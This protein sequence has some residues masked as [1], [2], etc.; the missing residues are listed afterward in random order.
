MYSVVSAVASIKFKVS[1]VH[2]SDADLRTATYAGAAKLS[3]MEGLFDLWITARHYGM[4]KDTEV[5]IQIG[6]L[7]TSG[8]CVF[9]DP[10]SDVSIVASEDLGILSSVGRIRFTSD[11]AQGRLVGVL[12]FPVNSDNNLG[13][14]T[15]TTGYVACTTAG[16]RSGLPAEAVNW[17]SQRFFMIDKSI[18][19]GVSGGPVI[20]TDG[21][22]L[23]ML[24]A[25]CINYSQVSWVLKSSYMSDALDA[26]V[27]SWVV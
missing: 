20:D 5:I 6:K 11:V 25:S 17:R 13:T 9:D 10:T 4:L 23:G 2:S 12:G 26:V 3:G 22:V 8:K 27:E 24:C 16:I 15:L 14:P 18:D 1:K 19:Y 21:G 7:T